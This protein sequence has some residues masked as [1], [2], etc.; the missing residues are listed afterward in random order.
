MIL[1]AVS[2]IDHCCNCPQL[3]FT[4]LISK[5]LPNKIRPHEDR[6]TAAFGLT[7]PEKV[8]TPIFVDQCNR[9]SKGSSGEISNVNDVVSQH[10]Y[11]NTVEG[12]QLSHQRTRTQF[13]YSFPSFYSYPSQSRT[14]NCTI[15]PSQDTSHHQ[16]PLPL[17]LPLPL[18]NY[19]QQTVKTTQDPTQDIMHNAQHPTQPAASDLEKQKYD[20]NDDDGKVTTVDVDAGGSS[21]N[22]RHDLHQCSVAPLEVVAVQ[23]E[24][25]G[26]ESRSGIRSEPGSGSKSESG[27]GSRSGAGS[28]S[29]S[30]SGA[31]SG[32][33]CVEDYL[34]A[35]A[36]SEAMT[37]IL[38]N[39]SAL[40][41]A[42][43]LTRE[44]ELRSR[45]RFRSRNKKRRKSDVDSGSFEVNIVN[46]RSD[47]RMLRSEGGGHRDRDGQD[48][49]DEESE[50]ESEKDEEKKLLLDALPSYPFAYAVR[51]LVNSLERSASGEEEFIFIF[52]VNSLV[53]ENGFSIATGKSVLSLEGLRGVG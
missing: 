9:D 24:S 19:T 4:L 36:Y 47:D 35:T 5:K 3:F 17:P 2:S 30:G 20:R 28:G 33:G 31:G 49:E 7:N 27:A 12:S 25:Y 41:V 43:S 53:D 40:Q 16:L 10:I 22:E 23:E 14:Y 34:V 52:R 13:L 44:Y 39:I 37:S 15:K 18:Q 50:I 46:D 11:R 21:A 45:D 32:S 1:Y 6:S 51:R 29:G 42:V 8:S 48:S 26:S 38:G